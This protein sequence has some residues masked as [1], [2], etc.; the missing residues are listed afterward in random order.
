MFARA[1]IRA[2]CAVLKPTNEV[3]RL[4]SL[5]RISSPRFS[6]VGRQALDDALRHLT[7][8]LVIDRSANEAANLVR[9]E[10]LLSIFTVGHLP[11]EIDKPFWSVERYSQRL[12]RH[13][14]MSGFSAIV[15]YA[16][17][18]PIGFAYGITL[19]TTTRW[20][21][22][23][24]P[25]LTDPTFTREDGHRTFALFEAIVTP[26]HQGDGI[27]R[28]I[29]D[30][31]LLQIR[32]GGLPAHP[33]AGSLPPCPTYTPP[34]R[35]PRTAAPGPASRN[36]AARLSIRTC[37]VSCPVCSATCRAKDS[38]ALREPGQSTARRTNTHG[39]RTGASG[40]S[41][42]LSAS[43]TTLGSR[44][45]ARWPRGHSSRS[46]SWPRHPNAACTMHHPVKRLL[47]RLSD[48]HWAAR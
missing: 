1:N 15:A 23:I 36:P 42:R 46:P 11:Q 3:A 10:T 21:A 16:N 37:R 47:A 12:D 13:A 6:L 40:N 30:E 27:G 38:G 35:A 2:V 41:T 7:H 33:G 44:T 19:A 17:E 24:Q 5:L 4:K 18:E 48:E 31:L 14:A 34:A 39:V 9:S 32:R 26:E 45:A 20:W 25:S 22:T 28:R 29:H 43:V 8:L